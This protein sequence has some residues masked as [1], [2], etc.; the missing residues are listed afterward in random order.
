MSIDQVF[1]IYCIITSLI[2]IVSVFPSMFYCIEFGTPR[3]NFKRVVFACFI[4]G[5]ALWI[6]SFFLGIAW[7]LAKIWDWLE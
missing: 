1:F 3:L 4:G 5:P 6:L 2:F 7:F